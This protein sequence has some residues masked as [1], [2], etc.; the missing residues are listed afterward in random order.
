MWTVMDARKIVIPQARQRGVRTEEQVKDFAQELRENPLINPVTLR[1]DE[2][3]TKFLV[4]GEG[5]LFSVLYL[6]TMNE[7]IEFG[8][9]TLAPYYIP[10]VNQ[11]TISELKAA[12]LEYAENIKR[13]DLT[14]QENDAAILN[15]KRLRGELGLSQKPKDIAGDLLVDPLKDIPSAWDVQKVSEALKRQEFSDD[16]AVVAAKSANEANKI[17]EKRMKAEH[18]R[19]LAEEFKERKCEHVLI[20]G[21]CLVE[22]PKMA[23][24]SFDIILSDPIYGIN[25]HEQNSFQ[26]IK[27]R[28]EG[29]HHNYD[30]SAENFD[31]MFSVMPD[32]LYRVAKDEANLFLFCDI[33]RFYE[34]A[35][36][37]A[38]AGWNVWK[39][40]MIWYKG[41]IGSLPEPKHGPRYTYEAILFARKGSRETMMVTHDVLTTPQT[42]GH[43]HPAGK[44]A[45]VYYDLLKM[46]ARPGDTVLDFNSGAGPVLVAANECNC[47]AT[48]VELDSTYASLQHTRKFNELG[49]EE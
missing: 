11:G 1:T 44:P 13:Q 23:D 22:V 41:N 43:V 46:V 37:F 40:P 14:W 28:A 19:K 6:G 12:E 18:N 15:L 5:R 30:D 35:E 9:K 32:E 26:R 39:R 42:T 3:G 45:R 36:V 49:D 2:D 25:A 17:I 16:P 27:H 48:T 8:G 4:A 29:K 10:F 20:E 21:D 33:G 31:M 24:G 47:Q 7:G 38:R 34:L